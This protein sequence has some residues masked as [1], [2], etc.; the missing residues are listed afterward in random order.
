MQLG[1]IFVI[2]EFILHLKS[3]QLIGNAC[4]V[5]CTTI[6]DVNLKTIVKG[7]F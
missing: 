6:D 7:A 4:A 3:A 5:Q 2:V 1:F